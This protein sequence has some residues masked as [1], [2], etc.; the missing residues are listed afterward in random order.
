MKPSGKESFLY[1]DA[2]TVLDLK[3]GAQP[4]P[5]NL[6]LRSLMLRGWLV[7]ADGKPVKHAVM[8]RRPQP[9]DW[10]TFPTV[11]TTVEFQTLDLVGLKPAGPP[12]SAVVEV[13]EGRFEVPI[14]D[15]TPEARF[16]SSPRTPVWAASSSTPVA[17][18]RA[19]R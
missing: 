5:V 4:A 8:L 6:H 16:S 11:A 19:T 15:R 17:R 14:N 7:G 2:W 13:A 1:P 18:R 9:S 3:P 12:V 10:M